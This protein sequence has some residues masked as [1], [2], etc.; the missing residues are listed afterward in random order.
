M[1]Q[2]T[3]LFLERTFPDDAFYVA[4]RQVLMVYKV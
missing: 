2:G 4:R 3:S 1:V